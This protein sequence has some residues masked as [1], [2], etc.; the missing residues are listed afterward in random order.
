MVNYVYDLEEIEKNHEEFAHNRA[1]A[2]SRHVRNLL[3][4][5]L[6]ATGKA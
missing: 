3:R 4:A 5:K 1:V 2:S 6:A